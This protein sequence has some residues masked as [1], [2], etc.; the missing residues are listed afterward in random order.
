LDFIY[1]V[2]EWLLERDHCA[3]ALVALT[4]LLIIGTCVG[5]GFLYKVRVCKRERRWFFSF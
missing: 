4:S 2:N 3:V 1:Q 5:M